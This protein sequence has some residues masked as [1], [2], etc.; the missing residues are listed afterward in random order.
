M[1]KTVATRINDIASA[2]GYDIAT[3]VDD[4]TVRT[5]SHAAADAMAQN[6]A[7]FASGGASVEVERAAKAARRLA[8]GDIV[9]AYEALGYQMRD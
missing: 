8:W 3:I 9:G 7:S 6:P 1:I 4:E 5:T 2:H